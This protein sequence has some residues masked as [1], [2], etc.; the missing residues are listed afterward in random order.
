MGTRTLTM[1]LR[2]STPPFRTLTGEILPGSIAEIAYLRLGGLDQ[3]VMIRGESVANP[4]LILVHGGPGFPELRLFRSFNRIARRPR[5]P[6][7]L[8]LVLVVP[9][10]FSLSSPPGNR[11]LSL[12]LF[13]HREQ[14]ISCDELL[15]FEEVY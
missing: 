5:S 9:E 15:T 4:L 10:P 8:E 3:W 2:G 14:G 1:R 7:H 11:N 13:L 6:S 12:E